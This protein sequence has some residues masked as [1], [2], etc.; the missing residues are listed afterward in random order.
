MER[1]RNEYYQEIDI[2]GQAK[3]FKCRIS[4]F[5]DKTKTLVIETIGENSPWRQEIRNIILAD[6]GEVIY[7]PIKYV[8]RCEVYCDEYGD[9][10]T[11]DY[12]VHKFHDIKGTEFVIHSRCDLDDKIIE[13]ISAKISATPGISINFYYEDSMV[14]VN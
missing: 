10:R 13:K 9:K 8:S 5:N 3:W 2:D 6:F 11:P 4:S 1:K 14:R 7:E 12:S